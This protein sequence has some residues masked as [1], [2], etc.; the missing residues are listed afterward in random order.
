[1][2]N[3]QGLEA[4][5]Q[6]FA[7]DRF[8]TGQTGCVIEKAGKNFSRCSVTIRPHH[9]NAAGTV[10]GGAIFTLAD[11]AFAVAA[12]CC[13]QP[14]TVSIS[15]QITYLAPPRGAHMTAH[16]TCVK[17]GRQ[18]CLYQVDIY[19]DNHTPVALVTIQGFIKR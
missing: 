19:D 16:C 12:N 4:L 10:M 5:Q 13:D 6:K 15:S 8:A 18:T 3:P 11:F 14:L 1:M 17:S 7:N 9:L 2:M